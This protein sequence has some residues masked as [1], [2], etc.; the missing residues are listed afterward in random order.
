MDN[1]EKEVRKTAIE[2]FNLLEEPFK[3]KCIDYISTAYNS[4]YEAEVKHASVQSAVFYAFVW[5]ATLEGR[6]YW[7]DVH[8]GIINLTMKPESNEGSYDIF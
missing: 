5:S 4:N 6:E 2:W 8:K 7:G 1:K 3:T